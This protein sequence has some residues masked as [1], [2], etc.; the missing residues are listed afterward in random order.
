[1][2]DALAKRTFEITCQG[3]DDKEVH[4][5]LK[6]TRADFDGQSARLTIF[7]GDQPIGGFIRILRWFRKEQ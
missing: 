4:V 3:D 7:D 2:A 6:G 5:T 1:M